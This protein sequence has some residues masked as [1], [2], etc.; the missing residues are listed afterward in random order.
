MFN[1]SNRSDVLK[2][3][4]RL[5]LHQVLA[6]SSFDKS[7]TKLS[8]ILYPCYE[9]KKIELN[10]GNGLSTSRNKVVLVGLSFDTKNLNST[11]DSIAE[12]FQNVI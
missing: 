2:D 8:M 7:D 11:V 4:F 1:L 5:D 10:C 3:S 12:V 9:Y 6:Y